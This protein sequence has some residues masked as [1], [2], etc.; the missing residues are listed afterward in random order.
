MALVNEN[1]IQRRRGSWSQLSFPSYSGHD[2]VKDNV[3]DD[4]EYNS[5]F[6]NRPDGI[7]SLLSGIIIIITMHRSTKTALIAIAILVCVIIVILLLNIL[8]GSN[9]CIKISEEETCYAKEKNPYRLYGTKTV[10]DKVRGKDNSLNEVNVGE[11]IPKVFY[12][13]CRHATRYPDKEDIEEMI[14]LIPDLQEKIHNNSLMGKVKMCN[15]DIE[16]L[17][18]W[19]E[20]LRPEYDNKM[21]KTGEDETKLLAQRFKSHFPSLLDG[22]YSPEKFKF[23]YTSRERTRSTAESFAEGLFGDQFKEINFNNS[24]NDMLE[25]HK[26]CKVM[27]KRCKDKSYDISEIDKFEKGNLMQDLIK[28]V[29]SRIGVRLN[30][31]NI[32]LIH[33]ACAFGYALKTGDTWCS[34]FTTDE[35]KV[36]EFGD[37]IDDYY[38]D[39]YG[40]EINYKQACPVV[41]F[42]LDLFRTYTNTSQS[43]VLLQ[44]SHAGSIKKVFSIFG[45]FKDENPLKADDICLQDRKWRSSFIAPFTANLALVLYDCGTERKVVAFHNEKPVKLND[46]PEILCPF[47]KFY[48]TYN[49]IA[50]ECDL[51]SICCTCCQN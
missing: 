6:W 40:N 4:S 13:F 18:K 2:A 3:I 17:S 8:S 51:K 35:L 5:R 39:A 22:S 7:F 26:E 47:E 11:C 41:D 23:E 32:K 46:C 16:N 15:E 1:V 28:S 43:K 12:L 27:Q 38:K 48:K 37:D 34:L 33:K 25:F 10:Y 36:M 30:Y 49:P 19:V 29:S 20:K 44:F 21:S 9:E 14:K 45:L 50:E 42:A 24:S 31:G